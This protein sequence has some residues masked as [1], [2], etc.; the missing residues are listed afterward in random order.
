MKKSMNQNLMKQTRYSIL[1]IATMLFS[2]TYAEVQLSTA[3]PTENIVS[4]SNTGT[5]ASRIID[6]DASE[7][8]A[9][10]QLFNL[11]GEEGTKCAITSITFVHSGSHLQQR[12]ADRTHV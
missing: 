1:A 10:G 3:A 5:I 8:H 6:I 4:S 7:N 9:R 2:V 12:Y 11:N